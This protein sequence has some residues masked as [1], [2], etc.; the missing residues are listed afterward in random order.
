LPTDP[1]GR[2]KVMDGAFYFRTWQLECWPGYLPQ[3]STG[4]FAICDG[5]GQLSQP[6]PLPCVKE[7]A[8]T[9]CSIQQIEDIEA[10]RLEQFPD[11]KTL[12]NN[13]PDEMRDG[14]MCGYKC[15]ST[16][17]NV[18]GYRC[19][20]GQIVGTPGCVAKNGDVQAKEVTL[21]A[22]E[23][24]ALVSGTSGQAGWAN[25]FE[26]AFG[27]VF[28]AQISYVG[29][30]DPQGSLISR[31][32]NARRLSMVEAD[33]GFDGGRRLQGQFKIVWDA[34]ILSTSTVRAD[35][36]AQ[37]GVALT[38][39]GSAE[40]TSFLDKITSAGFTVSGITLL[41]APRVF[42]MQVPVNSLGSV[43]SIADL[44]VPD[45]EPLYATIGTNT[46]VAGNPGAIIG[47]V[48]GGLLGVGCIMTCC[49]GYLQ[50][51]KRLRES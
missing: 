47:G 14:Q 20:Y 25:P 18:G 17:E 38:K 34:V 13:C 22:S 27:Q 33:S 51:R 48:V 11:K 4:G 6:I 1:N 31:T 21:V 40:Q 15:P 42:A 30:T 7:T 5:R 16:H 50:M 19:Q 9:N 45:A 3:K 41:M 43:Q 44:P 28:G 10:D 46:E 29:V 37:K 36:V 23:I 8:A 26:G 39:A 35:T 32:G 2:Y 24:Q 49:Y 12:P